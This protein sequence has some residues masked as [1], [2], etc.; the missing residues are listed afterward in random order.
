MSPFYFHVHEGDQLLRDRKGTE[1]EDEAAVRFEARFVA[2]NLVAQAI[3][4]DTK[5]NGREIVVENEAGA[6]VL[7]LPVQDVLKL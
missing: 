5:I 7:H 3:C 4:A 1:L 2:R 6:D